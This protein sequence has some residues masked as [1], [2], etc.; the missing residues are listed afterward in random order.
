MFDMLGY[1]KHLVLTD[2][3]SDIP[4]AAP[5]RLPP[6][7]LSVI[8]RLHSSAIY[9]SCEVMDYPDDLDTTSPGAN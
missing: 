2:I 4:G 3:F 5:G 7:K 9:I 8:P 1:P 6:G